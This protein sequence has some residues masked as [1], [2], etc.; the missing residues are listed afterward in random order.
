MLTPAQM[1]YNTAR[2]PLTMDPFCDS[3]NFGL[4]KLSLDVYPWLDA[5]SSTIVLYWALTVLPH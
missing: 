1:C 2:T 5:D 4:P 3:L